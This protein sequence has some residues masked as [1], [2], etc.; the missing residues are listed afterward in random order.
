[1]VQPSHSSTDQ[2]SRCQLS[3][4]PLGAN[5]CQAENIITT[6]PAASQGLRLPKR[7]RVRS[8]R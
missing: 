4:A 7:V 1:M 5:S 3:T 2:I 8:L 6:V